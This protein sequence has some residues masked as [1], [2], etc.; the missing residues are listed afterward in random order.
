MRKTSRRSREE[1]S[2]SIIPEDCCV[3]CRLSD[4]DPALFGEKVTVKEHRL[5]VHYFCLL[6]SC[7]V[8]Q[9]GK[10]NEGVLGFLVDDIKQEIRRSAR[11]TCFCCKKKGACVG[12]CVKRCR[13]MVHFPCGRKEKFISQFTS[14]FPSYCPDHGP[15]QSVCVGLDISLPQSCSICLDSLDPILSYSVLKCPACHASWFHRDCVQRQA[16]SAGLYFFRCTLCNNKESFQE[17]ML[18]MGIYIPERDA[19][20]ELEANAYSELLVVYTRCDGLTCLCD[21]GR[22]HSAKSGWFEVIRCR[23]CGSRGTHR[24]CSGLKVDTRDWACNDCTQSTDGKASLVASPQGGQRNCLLSKR[25]LTL[26]QTSISCKRP[27]FPVGSAEEILQS[28]ASQLCPNS[29]QVEVSSYQALS[30]GLSLV[31]RTDFDPTSSL[32]IRFKADQ[33]A[34]FPS[35]LTDSDVARQYFL[36]LLVQQIQASVV[37]EGPAGSKNLVL[38][39]Q[40]LREDLYFD[41]GCLLALSLVHGGPPLGFFSHA[42]Y[43]CLFNHPSN[44]PLTITHMTPDTHFTRQVIKIARAQSLED[45]KEAMLLNWEFLELAGCNRPISSLEERDALVEDL[46]SFTMITRMQLPLQRFRKGLQSLGV[47]DQ[48]QLFPSVFC[49][50]FCE[51]AQLTAQTITQLFTVQ[52]SQ[53]ERRLHREIPVIPFWRHFLMECEVG[54][55]SV[56]LQDLFHFATGAEELPATG[57][58]PPPSLSFLHPLNSSQQGVEDEEEED[59]NGQAPCMR[60]REEK[61]FPQSQPSS[62]QLFLPVTSSYQAFKSSMEQAISHH[63]HLLPS[64]R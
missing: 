24:K 53:K 10:E 38:D 47:F 62:N 21:S 59:E 12:C 1:G 36:K 40:A 61:L 5:S 42:L 30:A 46:I 39:S 29:V 13:K 23:L 9:R 19:S 28:L 54:R 33:Q 11:L 27:V 3:L 15:T 44:S 64:E 35:C 50:T 48:V 45:V 56:T 34:M 58:L 43:Q 32:S 8:Y 6:T 2:V 63:M 37:F 25:L 17:E 7:G 55:T 20:W 60:W 18:R 41:M 49:S 51:V 52:F 16:H 31:R 14:L 22:T 4:N 57:L 26:S